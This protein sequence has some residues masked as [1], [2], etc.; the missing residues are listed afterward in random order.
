[1]SSP[2]TPVAFTQR[3]PEFAGGQYSLSRVQMF[4]DDAA[5]IMADEEKWL[6]YY[7]VAQAYYVAHLLTIA[8][9]TVAGDTGV[10]AP[11]ALQ[12]VDNVVIQQAIT[13]VEATADELLS[14]SYGKRYWQYRRMVFAGPYGV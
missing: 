1:M 10:T 13:P 3:F 4:I 9:K 6:G 8:N 5:L 12:E 11:V 2:I 7:H 14:T